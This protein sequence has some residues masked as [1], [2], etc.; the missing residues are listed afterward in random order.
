MARGDGGC[1]PLPWRR[2]Q[3]LF[4]C[5]L[6]PHSHRPGCLDWL[7]LGVPHLQG[8][9]D[10][11]QYQLLFQPLK[12]AVMGPQEEEPGATERVFSVSEVSF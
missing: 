7:P 8:R 6:A 4:L 11:N 10:T 1:G 3:R 2:P 12:G 9:G 5:G